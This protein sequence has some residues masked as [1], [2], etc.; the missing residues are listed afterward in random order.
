MKN[1]TVTITVAAS[2]DEVFSFLADPK[3]LPE[4]A[5]TFSKSIAPK[6]GA[7]EVETPQGHKLAFALEADRSSG[8]I[9]MLAGPTL[10]QMESFP[11]R[12]YKV[13]SGQ[14]AASFTMFKSQRPDLTDAM[15]ETHY[16][17]LVKEVE[18]LVERFGGG[19]ISRGLPEGGR[20]L[21]GLVTDR[22]EE[23]RDFYVSHFG[24]KAVFDASCYVHLVREVGGEQL[25]LMATSAEAGQA[26]FE[27]AT[28]GSGLWF[29]LEVESADAEFERLKA[30]G[31]TVRE[32]PK[33]QPWGERT[34]VVVDP[35]GV[36]IY[37]SH[38]T[39]KVDESLKPFF[40]ASEPELVS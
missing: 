4:W 15:F 40:V 19:E 17:Q 11:I 38:T 35:N 26:E 24:F 10:E 23:T 14:T 21:P 5:H 39:G 6:D 7:W 25:G 31:V 28:T 13:D 29:T 34:C 12:V 20:L 32:E 30:E 36:L 27:V 33:D 8:C 18:A 3:T 37:V 16:R 1:H 9:D 22:I 2:I